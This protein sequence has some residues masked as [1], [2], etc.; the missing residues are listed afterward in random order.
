MTTANTF[1]IDSAKFEYV[2][3]FAADINADLARGW[4]C[5]AGAEGYADIAGAMCENLSGDRFVTYM[6]REWC[7]IYDEYVEREVCESASAFVAYCRE[8]GIDDDAMYA[9]YRAGGGYVCKYDAA[10]AGWFQVHTTGLCA[11]KLPAIDD[12]ALVAYVDEAFQSFAHVSDDNVCQFDVDDVV[13][14]VKS[15]TVVEGFTV[16]LIEVESTKCVY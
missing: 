8:N 1:N 7:D 10:R 16:H 11:H 14:I 3:R 6:R 15:W 5:V 2:V 12:N 9:M 13:R 4:S